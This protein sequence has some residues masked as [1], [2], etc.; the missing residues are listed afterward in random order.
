MITHNNIL[1]D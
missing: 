1:M